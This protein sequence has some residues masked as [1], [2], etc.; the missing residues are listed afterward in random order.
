MIEEHLPRF[1]ETVYRLHLHMDVNHPLFRYTNTSAAATPD[2]LA[3]NLTKVKQKRVALQN[4][5]QS[6]STIIN[7]PVK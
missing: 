6:K 2:E 1:N 3:L 4:E 5:T 7:P